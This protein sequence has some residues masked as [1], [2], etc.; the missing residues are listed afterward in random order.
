MRNDAYSSDDDDLGDEDLSILNTDYAAQ[1]DLSFYPS[2]PQTNPRYNPSIPPSLRQSEH[3]ANHEVTQ[4]D[5]KA[6]SPVPPGASSVKESTHHGSLDY[7]LPQHNAQ[8][9]QTHRKR[10][11][12]VDMIKNEWMTSPYTSSSSSPTNHD[13]STP[14]WLQIFSAPRF[15]RYIL[16]LV[17]FICLVWGNW[18]FWIGA[19]WREHRL[20]SESIVE[21]MKTGGGWFGENM[22]PEFLDMVH[23]KT[24]DQ[25]LL[26]SRGDEKRL[27]VIG[28][29]HGCHDEC[30]SPQIPLPIHSK[31]IVGAD[32]E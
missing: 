28:D 3:P 6:R 14:H 1:R 7:R 20:L 18:H 11:P 27:I 29:V 22:R 31:V 16:I 19:S 25:G 2:Q 32:A 5:S 17:G 4:H 13:Y 24:L 30:Q 8:A 12:L 23:V 15:R 10:R 21:R 9:Y 26:P